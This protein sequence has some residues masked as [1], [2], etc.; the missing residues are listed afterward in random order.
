MLLSP[1]PPLFLSLTIRTFEKIQLIMA[2]LI[3]FVQSANTIDSTT[4]I[5][6]LCDYG[7]LRF[8]NETKY[9]YITT[10]FNFALLLIIIL[11]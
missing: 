9:T 10:K 2:S 4:D 7:N 3:R 5:R 8:R 1:Q 11:K 6:V